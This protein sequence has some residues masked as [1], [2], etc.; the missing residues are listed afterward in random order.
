MTTDTVSALLWFILELCQYL[1]L[2]STDQDMIHATNAIDAHAQYFVVD[3]E[4]RLP[5]LKAFA[6]FT[7]SLLTTRYA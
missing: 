3:D 1:R 7:N 4:L 6:Q 2:L 5:I